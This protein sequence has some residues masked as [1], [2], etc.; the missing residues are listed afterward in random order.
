MVNSV[1][2]YADCKRR[3]HDQHDD[4]YAPV[5]SRIGVG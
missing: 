5:Q 3:R 4:R 2:S 1:V